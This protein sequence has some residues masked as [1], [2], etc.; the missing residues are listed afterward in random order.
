MRSNGDIYYPSNSKWMRRKCQGWNQDFRYYM[1]VF[2]EV[3][4]V[5]IMIHIMTAWTRP[6]TTWAAVGSGDSK[7]NALSEVRGPPRLLSGGM[8]KHDSH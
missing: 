6:R 4:V 5:S 8:S 2:Q 3:D 7:K 1:F